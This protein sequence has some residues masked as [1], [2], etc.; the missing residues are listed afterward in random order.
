[1]LLTILE[2][3]FDEGRHFS[4]GRLGH[5]SCSFLPRIGLCPPFREPVG[6]WV[7]RL[8]AL[9][10]GLGRELGPQGILTNAIAPSFIDTEQLRIDARGDHLDRRRDRDLRPAHPAGPPWLTRRAPVR[11]YGLVMTCFG[12]RT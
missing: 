8:I 7:R 5:C 1:M 6:P 9:T 12:V 2:P 10:K 4:L 11:R 3:D